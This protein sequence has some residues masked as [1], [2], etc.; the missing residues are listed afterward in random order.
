M[1]QPEDGGGPAAYEQA[2]KYMRVTLKNLYTGDR[3]R[4]R[5]DRRDDCDCLTLRPPRSFAPRFANCT[6]KT[7]KDM[8]QFA[9]VNVRTSSHRYKTGFAAANKLFTNLS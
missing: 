7:T 2:I 4:G 6:R 9:P 3:N 5:I 1:H 8:D